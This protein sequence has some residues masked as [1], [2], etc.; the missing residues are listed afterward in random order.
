MR[1]KTE[2]CCL[3]LIDIQEKLIPLISNKDDVVDTSLDLIDIAS[4]LKIPIILTEQYPKGL[5]NTKKIIKDSLIGKDFF[6]IEKTSFSCFDSIDFKKQLRSLGKKQI[7]IAGIESHICVMQT[8]LDLKA[9]GYEIFLVEKAI[10]S[11]KNSDRML[12][13][14]RMVNSKVCLTSTEML[15]FELVRDSKHTLFKYF[16]KKYI[17]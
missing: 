2:E 6:M 14:N 7:I 15:I 10:G 4:N 16:S 17:K 8:V 5:G 1:I 3:L 13:L 11:R 12:G 9:S